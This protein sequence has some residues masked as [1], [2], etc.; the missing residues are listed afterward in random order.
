MAILNDI[1][2]LKIYVQW[3]HSV[4]MQEEVRLFVGIEAVCGQF[5]KKKNWN[6]GYFFDTCMRKFPDLLKRILKCWELLSYETLDTFCSC[7]LQQILNYLHLLVNSVN[8]IFFFL[9]NGLLYWHSVYSKAE[10][11]DLKSWQVWKRIFLGCLCGFILLQALL[12]Q[13]YKT[14]PFLV[15]PVQ[16]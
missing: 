5:W 2:H 9:S 3:Q 6:Q 16:P 10:K 4:P 15:H 12:G 13:H 8:A 14:V 7:C 11:W 1:V